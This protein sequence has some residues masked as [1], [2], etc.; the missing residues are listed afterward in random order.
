MGWRTRTQSFLYV[1]V[2]RAMWLPKE[3]DRKVDATL[4]AGFQVTEMQGVHQAY[5]GTKD[6]HR[7]YR[8]ET[9][10]ELKGVKSE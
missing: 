3:D 9:G 8:G 6:C 4:V 7:I 5:G 10:S 1:G 2:R